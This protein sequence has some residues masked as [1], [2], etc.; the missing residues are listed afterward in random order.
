MFV[1][2]TMCTPL[3]K[4]T[5]INLPFTSERYS[6]LR[7]IFCY[8]KIDG[9]EG[10]DGTFFKD[11]SQIEVALDNALINA[12]LGCCIGAG[13]GLHYSYID[14]AFMNLEK[15]VA[16]V[17]EVLQKGNITKKSWILFFDSELESEWIGIWDESPPPPM[18]EFKIRI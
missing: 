6:K 18:P 11:R 5:H 1:G 8:L 17:K 4:N 7:E 15:G 16:I 12:R 13:T 2:K 14:L 10:L 3:W 9:R